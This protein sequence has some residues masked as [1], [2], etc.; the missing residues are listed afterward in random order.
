MHARAGQPLQVL[1][2]GGSQGA[3]IL[4]EI[5][6]EALAT[7]PEAARPVVRH[8]AGREL[9]AA[10]AEGCSGSRNGRAG[11]RGARYKRIAHLVSEFRAHVEVDV[12]GVTLSALVH[13]PFEEQPVLRPVLAVR[14]LPNAEAPPDPAAGR[15]FPCRVP[16]TTFGLP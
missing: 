3:R 13:E 4:N 9:A 16:R 15:P 14:D 8:Q 6:P 1:V 10:Q 5:V 7:I 11:V 12:R 2:I